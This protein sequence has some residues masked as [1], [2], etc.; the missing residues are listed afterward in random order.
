MGREID[1]WIEGWKGVRKTKLLS[2]G[3]MM[4]RVP[5]KKFRPENRLN[6][7]T[8]FVANTKKNEKDKHSKV[9]EYLRGFTKTNTEISGNVWK[10]H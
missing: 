2:V 1:I 3:K 5:W 7:G 10:T 6:F 9:R 4:D 8:D